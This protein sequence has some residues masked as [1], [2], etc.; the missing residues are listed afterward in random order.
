VNYLETKRIHQPFNLALDSKLFL[1]IRI[2]K[3][4]TNQPGLI[5]L[6]ACPQRSSL[7]NSHKSQ[8]ITF[9]LTL[10]FLFFLTKKETKKVKAAKKWLKITRYAATGQTRP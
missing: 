7:E 3:A 9:I 8:L 2:F 4:S 10:F 5:D 6:S 1:Q